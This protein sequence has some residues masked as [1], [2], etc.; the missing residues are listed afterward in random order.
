MKRMDK[1]L[2]NYEVQ[3]II[4]WFNSE[5]TQEFSKKLPMSIKWSLRKNMTKLNA[6][7]K[8][9]EEERK[10]LET[11]YATDEKSDEIK[12]VN[13]NGDEQTVREVKPEFLEKFQQEQVEL[14]MQN[15]DIRLNMEKEEELFKIEDSDFSIADLDML[16]FMII[17]DIEEE[18]DSEDGK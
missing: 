6:L 5:S 4:A 14:L 2:N 17:E 15:N 1:T 9:Y 8:D 7:S 12:R 11:K 10:E 13:E 3:N 16:S 18:E